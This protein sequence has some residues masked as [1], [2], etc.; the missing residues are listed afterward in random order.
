MLLAGNIKVQAPIQRVW[1]MLLEPETLQAC[2]P[3]IE[4]IER[5]DKRNYAIVIAQKVG[6]FTVRFPIKATLTK[7]EAP[8]HLEVEGQ[9]E[10]KGKSDQAV[11]KARIDLREAM[12]GVIEISYTVEAHI[13]GMPDFL[14]EGIVQAKAKKMEAEIAKV[15][16]QRLDNGA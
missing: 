9:R 6:P 3:G 5:L 10:D 11:H 16:Q 7:A 8:H 2:L 12:G 15:L 14:G 13:A 4:T 1:D